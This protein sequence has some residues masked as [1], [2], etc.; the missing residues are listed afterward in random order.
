[1]Q[2]IIKLIC[3]KITPTD[4][5][6]DQHGITVKRKE[7]LTIAQKYNIYTDIFKKFQDEVVKQQCPTFYP[8]PSYKSDATE[9]DE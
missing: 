6:L 3:N 7:A 9:I 2:K 8:P 4:T 5:E 1:M